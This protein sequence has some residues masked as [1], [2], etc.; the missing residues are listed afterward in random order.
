MYK[1]RARLLG[2]LLALVVLAAACGDDDDATSTEAAAAETDTADDGGDGSDDMTGDDHSHGDGIEVPAG[3]AVPVIAIEVTPDAKAGQNLAVSLENFTIAP[4]RASTAPVDGEGHLHLYVDGER[5]ARFYNQWMY[6][7]LE[8]GEHVVEVEV[9]ANNHSAYTVDGMPIRAQATIEVPDSSEHHH[10]SGETVD[11]Q[12]DPSPAVT[13]EVTED[14]KKGWN[15]HAEVANFVIAPEKASSEHVDGEGHMHLY[16]DGEKI[17]RLYGNWWH[18]AALTEGTHEIMVEVS[19]NDH[20]AYAKDG[21]PIVAT[22][23]ID[24]P[25]DKATDPAAGSMDGMDH[26]DGSAMD[27]DVDDA[28]VVVAVSF[29]DGAVSVDDDRIGVERGATVAV[30]VESDVDE[31]IHV[32]GYDVFGDV[33]AGETSVVGFEADVPGVFE[34]ELED[35]VT[36]VTELIVE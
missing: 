8:P 35:S 24:V 19:A 32:H 2:A 22:T 20:R 36:F 4:E 28:D 7:S 34:V 3:M 17:T 9:S 15:L 10:P 31:R 27:I 33:V 14:P 6:L 29:V 26:M 18:V 11:A 16:I 23:T 21:V 1:R 13:V 25:A 5:K 30:A 12:A